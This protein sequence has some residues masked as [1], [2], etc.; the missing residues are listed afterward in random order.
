MIRSDVDDYI[1]TNARQDESDRSVALALIIQN[2]G[3]VGVEQSDQ[4]AFKR[5]R[6]HGEW[7][8]TNGEGV[9]GKGFDFDQ[10]QRLRWFYRMLRDDN[11]VVGYDPSFPPE[12]GVHNMGGFAYSKREKSDGDLLIRVNRFVREDITEEAVPAVPLTVRGRLQL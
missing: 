5:L 12:P 6:D 1:S 3:L 8:L 9:D 11:V 4:S 10:R 2:L 7:V